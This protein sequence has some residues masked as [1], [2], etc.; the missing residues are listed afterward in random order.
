M[1]QRANRINPDHYR[2]EVRRAKITGLQLQRQR[3]GT[4]DLGLKLLLLPASDAVTV[5]GRWAKTAPMRGFIGPFMA[6]VFANNLAAQNKPSCPRIEACR[7][8]IY[9]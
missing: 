2:P 6:T 4:C 7:A 1:F 9:C 5:G 8:A 3:R